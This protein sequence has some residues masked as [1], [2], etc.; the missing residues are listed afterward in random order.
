MKRCKFCGQ[1][2]IYLMQYIGSDEPSFYFPGSHIRGF[3][4]TPVCE[5]CAD[6]QREANREANQDVVIPTAVQ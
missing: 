5:Q 4:T 1:P 6:K 3:G 2:A